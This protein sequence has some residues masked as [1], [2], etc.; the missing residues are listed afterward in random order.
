MILFI[1]VFLSSQSLNN[2]IFFYFIRY[3]A[4]DYIRHYLSF[5]FSFEILFV[6]IY[7]RPRQLGSSSPLFSFCLNLVKITKSQRQR[8]Q[9]K[10]GLLSR[11]H[12]S[13][14]MPESRIDCWSVA[15]LRLLKQELTI[16]VARLNS[17]RA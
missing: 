6:Y 1:I 7:V 13:R 15:N 4:Y 9:T 2:F 5:F 11:V 17:S 16:T 3:K 12:W 8:S 14:R 10:T